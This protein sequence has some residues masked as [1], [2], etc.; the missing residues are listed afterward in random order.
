MAGFVAGFRELV[1]AGPL[2]GD[3]LAGVEVEEVVATA[4]VRVLLWR[5]RYLLWVTHLNLCC[6]LSE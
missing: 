1:G 2:V 3:G 6:S 4:E 5:K